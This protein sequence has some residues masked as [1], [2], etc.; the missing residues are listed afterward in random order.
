[1]NFTPELVASVGLFLDIIG[2]VLIWRYGLGQPLMVK[3]SD[4]KDVAVHLGRGDSF[5]LFRRMD[6]L[7]LAL[8]IAG[9]AL[10]ILANCL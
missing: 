1:M 2:V 10:Q 9:F 5:K 3:N 6:R 7:G 8:L 4:G